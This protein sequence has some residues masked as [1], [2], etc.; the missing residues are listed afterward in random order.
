MVN[1]ISLH[2]P[3]ASFCFVA[4]C[5]CLFYFFLSIWPSVWL[6]TCV[7]HSPSHL[8]AF[9]HRNAT[10]VELHRLLFPVS[11]NKLAVDAASMLNKPESHGHVQ[12]Q[13]EP[14]QLLSIYLYCFSS[15]KPNEPSVC[16]PVFIQLGEAVT[17]NPGYLKLRKIRAAQNIAKT[18][19]MK[20]KDDFIWQHHRVLAAHVKCTG[21]FLFTEIN[22]P[23]WQ[24]FFEP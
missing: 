10:L 2:F 12:L 22:K 17:K 5:S 8:D 18:V 6:S 20:D 3:M 13:Q 9:F 24:H 21:F 1:F 23:F 4:F 11:Q 19:R 7:S 14:L 15:S 16:L